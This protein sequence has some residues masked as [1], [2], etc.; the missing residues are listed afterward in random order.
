MSG[1]W[2]NNP[3]TKRDELYKRIS[4]TLD[5]LLPVL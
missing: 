2:K 3:H 1:F 5:E 4:R